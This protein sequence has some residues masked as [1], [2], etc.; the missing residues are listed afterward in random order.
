MDEA[1]RR[2]IGKQI[3]SARR[4]RGMSQATLAAAAHVAPNT[5]G[6]I[7]AGHNTRPGSLAKVMAFLGIEPEVEK[8]WRVGLPPDVHLLVEA[9]AL[10]FADVPESERPAE[11]LRLWRFLAT[12]PDAPRQ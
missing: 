6:S 8:Q 9:V 10:W 7:E 12:P 11:M 1:Q 4:A 2:A 5:V 3:A